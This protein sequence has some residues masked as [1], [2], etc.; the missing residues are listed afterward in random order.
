MAPAKKST[1]SMSPQHK[2]A[3]AEGRRQGRAVRNYLEALN[4]H[5]PKR[6]RKR[7]P[8][9]IAARLKKI[10]SEIERADAVRRVELIQERLNLQD[11]LAAHENK[12]D[13]ADLEAEF[14][15]C[16]AAYSERKGIT[17]AAWREA[18]VPA[19]TLTA[20]GIGRGR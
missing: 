8:D 2:A 14:I 7:T 16:A 15:D 4:A 19:S 5:K 11:E 1:K 10:E 13:I 17:Y 6:G 12:V 18:G 9:S 3:L 20:A